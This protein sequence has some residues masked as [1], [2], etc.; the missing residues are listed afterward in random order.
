MIILIEDG[1]TSTNL[2]SL[3]IVVS[4]FLA[5]KLTN[6]HVEFIRRQINGVVY[7]HELAKATI[8]LPSLHIFDEIS[9]C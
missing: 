4:N 6:S 8:S 3:W 9:T 7:D 1:E 2:V 5:P